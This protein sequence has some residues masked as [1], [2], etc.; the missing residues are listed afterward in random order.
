MHCIDDRGQRVRLIPQHQL[1]IMPG[2]PSPIP[3]DARMR[4]FGK[5]M[6][7]SLTRRSLVRQGIGLAA[8]LAWGVA[9]LG[10]SGWISAA[11]PMSPIV[12]GLVIGVGP[13]LGVPPVM[14]WIVRSHR[15]EVARMVVGEHHCASCGYPLGEIDA[16]ADGCTVC[17]EC[18]SAWRLKSR[19]NGVGT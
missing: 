10:L 12:K 13:M 8:I 3:M 17:P 14:W 15:Q 5:G 4:M 9:W 11:L 19:G 7:L 1:G 18:G 16:A 2:V 6:D